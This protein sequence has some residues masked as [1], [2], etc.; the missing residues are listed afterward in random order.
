MMLPDFRSV[1]EEDDLFISYWLEDSLIA[2][3]GTRDEI[4]ATVKTPL[5]GLDELLRAFAEGTSA[6]EQ[7]APIALEP[8]LL[9]SLGALIAPPAVVEA[10]SRTPANRLIIFP[11]RML[12]TLP[13]HLLIESRTER[14]FSGG[15]I[16][17][18]S[19]SAYAY[20]CAKKRDAP[21]RRAVVV[22]GDENDEELLQEAQRVQRALPCPT[23]I[24]SRRSDMPKSDDVD[25]LY[26]ATHGAA[27]AGIAG[28]SDPTQSAGWRL[29]FDGSWIDASDFLGG[30]IKLARG[31]VVVLSACN[32]GHVMAGPV[33]ELN[34]LIQSILYAGAATILAARWPIFYATAEAVFAGT[35]ER[36]VSGGAT[37][38]A[39]FS[40]AIESAVA[41][42]EIVQLMAGPESSIFLRGPF[43][44]F[45]NGA[46]INQR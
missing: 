1:L 38:A 11:D 19:A 31:S 30:R 23:E 41:Q 10:I 16:Y 29:Q 37:F 28:G 39:A 7:D 18:P 17:A 21:P 34:G 4:I 26:I 45:G 40:D 35:I 14:R 15:V 33:H 9:S 20:A 3:M 25:I 42:P 46:A 8:H 22:L 5:A 27:P 43:I 44:L 24:V 12:H 6:I 13:I 32:V 36:V 2:V